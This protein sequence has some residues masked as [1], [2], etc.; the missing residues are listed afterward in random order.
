[1]VFKSDHRLCHFFVEIIDGRNYHTIYDTCINSVLLVVLICV[2]K[3]KDANCYENEHDEGIKY[4]EPGTNCV[5]ILPVYI[6]VIMIELFI[7]F[8]IFP[9]LIGIGFDL[10]KCAPSL[11]EL[12]L[13]SLPIFNENCD[14]DADSQSIR[15]SIK[16]DKWANVE[17]PPCY[18]QPQKC[19]DNQSYGIKVHE[20]IHES[21]L[22]SKV[23]FEGV[24]LYEIDVS[25]LDYILLDNVHD[26]NWIALLIDIENLIH[27]MDHEKT[28]QDL[29]VPQ[30]LDVD[31]PV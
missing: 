22:F 30:I 17:L 11:P 16:S 1:M 5:F 15:K 29:F 25:I 6:K 24:Q 9:D 19:W 12:V 18:Q 7:S 26:R 13:M 14:P 31:L 8:K 4:Q 21:H 3:R 10:G 20:G 23:V 28:Y 27:V 2:E